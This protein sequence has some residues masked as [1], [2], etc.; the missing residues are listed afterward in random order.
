MSLITQT[1]LETAFGVTEVSQLADRDGD[2]QADGEVVDA[3]ISQAEVVIYSY[4]SGRVALP[5]PAQ[6][7]ATSGALLRG[8]AQDIARYHLYSAQ[9]TDLVQKRYDQAIAWLK[10]FSRGMSSLPGLSDLGAESGGVGDIAY[11]APD[12]V[13]TGTTLADY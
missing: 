4:I 9:P 11:S 13:F 12:R 6:V 5:L 7:P 3:A 8:L 1:D 10:D 2:G